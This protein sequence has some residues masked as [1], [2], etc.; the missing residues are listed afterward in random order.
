MCGGVAT[1]MPLACHAA[2]LVRSADLTMSYLYC[3]RVGRLILQAK[4]RLERTKFDSFVHQRR[5][6]F[7][8]NFTAALE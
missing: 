2:A 7:L 3:Q 4:K 6:L 5:S 8:A 1:D